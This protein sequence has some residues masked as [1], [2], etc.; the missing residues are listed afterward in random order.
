MQRRHVIAALLPAGGLAL[1]APH[2]TAAVEWHHRLRAGADGSS[3][4]VALTLD[5]CGG[6]YDA[7]LIRLLATLRVP[8]T[9]FVT[10]R[11]LDRHEAALRELL[12]HPELFELENHGTAHVPAIVGA[13]SRLY[14]MAGQPDVNHLRAEVLGAADRIRAVS[15]RAPRY[16]RGAGAAYD[17]TGRQTIEALGFRI[18]GFSVNADGGATLPAQAVAARLRGVKPGDV[19]IAHVNRP[20]GGTAKGFAAALPEL[21]QRGLRFVKLSEAELV[22]V[23]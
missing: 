4:P 12:A 3:P 7:E 15:G 6:G 20:A 16:F 22:R 2:A 10:K 1:S 23:P 18:A 9:F 14:G 11:W 21:R 8:A 13:H 17:D 5:A 19:V